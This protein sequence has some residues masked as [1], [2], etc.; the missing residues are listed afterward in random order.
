MK[1]AILGCGYVGT[2]LANFWHQ[3][4]HFVTAT[5]T[6]SERVAEVEAVADRALV[7]RG[8]DSEA[9]RSL[10]QHHDTIAVTVAP[11]SDRQV[12]AETYRKTY[13]PTVQNLVS[14]LT[15]FPGEKQIIYLSSCAVYGN[16]NGEWVDET[17]PV[18]PDDLHGMVL[19]E[20]EQILL[21]AAE[22]QNNRS[23]DPDF[24]TENPN[25]Q[26]FNPVESSPR[27]RACILRLGGI[28]GPDRE[29]DKR[30]NRLAGKTLPGTG[31][32]ITNWIH[33]TD[34]VSAIAFLCDRQ[35]QGI[36]N[37]VDDVKIPVRELLDLVCDRQQLPRILWDSSQP[38]F[39]AF[40]ARVSNAKIK[41]AGY[42]FIY[43]QTAI[44]EWKLTVE[45]ENEN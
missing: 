37:L 3:Q 25:F 31:E 24:Q 20:A 18:T 14:A 39:R 45:T 33:Q 8:D 38:N 12:D 23:F 5:T 32:N 30:F 2:A 29:L 15:D 35:G 17:T 36:Y 10:V 9:M 43:P 28:Y 1:V 42:D 16:K 4:G 11:I 41:A 19:Y 22:M 40:N 26:P 44:G 27:W 13:I 34:I 21:Q 6:R 7:M